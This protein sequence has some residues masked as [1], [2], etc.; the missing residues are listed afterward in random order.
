MTDFILKLLGRKTNAQSDA[1]ALAAQHALLARVAKV[2]EGAP[3][4]GKDA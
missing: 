2:S 1:V 4:P 3:A